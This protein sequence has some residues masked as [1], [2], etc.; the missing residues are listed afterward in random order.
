MCSKTE[1]QEA[2][3]QTYGKFLGLAE[4]VRWLGRFIQNDFTNAPEESSNALRIDMMDFNKEARQFIEN[5]NKT[6][7]STNNILSYY[8]DKL[9]QENR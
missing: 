2:Q 8:I 9:E 1:I 5:F 7:N 6:I 4:D 3:E